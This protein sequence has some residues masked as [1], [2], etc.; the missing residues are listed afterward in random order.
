MLMS[1][2]ERM[3]IEAHSG[4]HHAWV[5][6]LPLSF[7]KYNLS[8][9]DWVAA[10]RRRLM[11]N[12]FPCQKHCLFCKEGWCDVK[13]DHAT[14]CGGGSS[15]VVRHSTT[16]KT[17]AKAVRDIGFRTD[18]EHGGGLGDQRRPGD[19]IVY[20]WRDGR[21][22]LIDVAII[23]P[24]CPAHRDSLISEGVGGAATAYG[25]R[26]ERMYH[27]LNFSKYE[28]LPFII[29][30]TGGWSSAAYGFCEEIR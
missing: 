27:D 15:R 30:T 19:V 17:I 22:L 24:L 13:G 23:N 1:T 16:R 10:A 4:K 14:M 21:H 5:N 8:S 3:H 9:P 12:V 29:E 28:F 2:R 25:R 20:N 11:L 26:K 6:V 18:I 7:K